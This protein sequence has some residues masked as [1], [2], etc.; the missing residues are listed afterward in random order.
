VLVL[1]VVFIGQRGAGSTLFPP[2]R[3]AGGTRPSC[4]VTTLDELDNGCG[5]QGTTPLVSHYEGA[6]GF[7]F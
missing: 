4:P 7:G 6:W 3:C 1:R 5:L 2:Y